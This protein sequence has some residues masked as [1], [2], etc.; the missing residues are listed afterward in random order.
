MLPRLSKTEKAI[1]IA[2]LI[3]LNYTLNKSCLLKAVSAIARAL[4]KLRKPVNQQEKKKLR[5][6]INLMSISNTLG[7]LGALLAAMLPKE[8]RP[9]KIIFA[10]TAI[11][12]I[13]FVV[14]AVI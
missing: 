10:G 1:E 3:V 9:S 4:H 7:V 2:D 6:W 13:F 5:G 11:A 12:G 8:L 14:F